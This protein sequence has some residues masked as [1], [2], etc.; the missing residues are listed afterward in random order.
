[1]EPKVAG[2]KSQ[3]INGYWISVPDVDLDK[4]NSNGPQEQSEQHRVGESHNWKEGVDGE[5]VTI[6]DSKGDESSKLKELILS[7]VFV[8]KASENRYIYYFQKLNY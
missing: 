1:M 2:F 6:A 8:S 7:K 3:E 5:I 4:E